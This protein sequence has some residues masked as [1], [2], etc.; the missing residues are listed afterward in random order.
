M[1]GGHSSKIL[2]CNLPSPNSLLVELNDARIVMKGAIVD[3]FRSQK[4]PHL[5]RMGLITARPNSPNQN[6][7]RLQ[8]NNSQA[9]ARKYES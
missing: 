7:I 3:M 4:S 8:C 9:V 5:Q 1:P 6:Q 2:E